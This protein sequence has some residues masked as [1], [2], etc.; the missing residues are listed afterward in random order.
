MTKY[1]KKTSRTFKKKPKTKKKSKSKKKVKYDPYLEKL[2]QE[3]LYRL[4]EQILSSDI[5]PEI[6]VES[7]TREKT[8]TLEA[9]ETLIEKHTNEIL[10][11]LHQKGISTT[12][13]IIQKQD[14]VAEMMNK[15][16]ARMEENVKK[17]P[18]K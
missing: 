2:I 6:E 3:S 15:I 11:E 5:A 18:K 10:G 13:D 12:D 8:A 7:T 4:A 14:T 1:P 9:T 16:Q 17:L